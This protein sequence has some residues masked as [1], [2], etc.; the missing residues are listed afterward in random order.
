MIDFNQFALSSEDLQLHQQ[1]VARIEASI[2][3]GMTPYKLWQYRRMESI[4]GSDIG[5]IM[6]VNKYSTPHQLWLEKTGRVEPWQ[7]NDA[8]HWGQML[9]P[10]IASEY[11]KISGMKLLHCDGLQIPQIPYLIGSPDRIVVNP[12]DETK[13]VAIWEGKTTRNNVAT[14]KSDENGR[15][16]IF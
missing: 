9:E 13:A 5:T 7:G 16:F 15:T 10:V 2:K 12:A 1:R 4:G 6:G 14:Y 3:P 11:E 8:T